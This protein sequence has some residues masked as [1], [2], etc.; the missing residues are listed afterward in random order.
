MMLF[1]IALISLPLA[2]FLIFTCYRGLKTGK[3]HHTDSQSTVEYSQNPVLFLLIFGVF[4]FFIV[5]LLA[6]FFQALVTFLSA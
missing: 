3:L 1:T 2:G 6:G 5:V 4:C